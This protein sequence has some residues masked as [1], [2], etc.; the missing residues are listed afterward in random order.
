MKS[1][2][3]NWP[4]TDCLHEEEQDYEWEKLKELDETYDL[5]LY[6]LNDDM[7]I[8]VSNISIG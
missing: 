1:S 4:C 7:D 6:N 5:R 8:G 3:K 2:K